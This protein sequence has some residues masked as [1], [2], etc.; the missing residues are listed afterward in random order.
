MN[1]WPRLL[2]MLALGGVAVTILGSLAAWLS[3]E[4]RRIGRNL[5]R[6]LKGPP[7]AMVLARGRGRAA[8]FN[9]SAGLAAVAWDGGAWMLVYRLDELTGAEILVD[10]RIVARIHRREPRR[11]LD[12]AVDQA[13]RVTLRLLFDDARY[14]TFDL[15]LWLAGDEARRGPASP[16]EAVADADRWLT[17][18]E[19]VLRRP[20]APRAPVGMAAGAPAPK[21]TEDDIDPFPDDDEPPFRLNDDRMV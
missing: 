4:E 20:V 1:E 17:R 12:E 8:A 18:A 9:L 16:A 14:P 3:N 6:V 19:A 15:D 21:P 7:E 10:G 13:A 11:P 2:L 5:A